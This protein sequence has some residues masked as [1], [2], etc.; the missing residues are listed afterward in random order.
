MSILKVI[1]NPLI[2]LV[3]RRERPYVFSLYTFPLIMKL[4]DKCLVHILKR[5]RM[6]R[7]TLFTPSSSSND[8]FITVKTCIFGRVS[9]MLEAN[10]AYNKLSIRF[11]RV[12][13]N[14][15]VIAL[16]VADTC[17]DF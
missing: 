5:V 10:M 15:I 12:G 8:S 16:F 4:F 2:F 17:V 3:E 13:D 7:L 6:F 14:A 9:A 11:F 1:L